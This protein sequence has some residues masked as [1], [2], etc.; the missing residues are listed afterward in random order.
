MS[1]TIRHTTRA[2]TGRMT[3]HELRQFLAT[4]ENLTGEATIEA[5]V[6][7]GGKLKTLTVEAETEDR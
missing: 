7:M 3:L 4:I 5:T 2:A 6:T 1:S